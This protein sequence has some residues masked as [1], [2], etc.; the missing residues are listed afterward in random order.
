MADIMN[1]QQPQAATPRMQALRNLSNQ[2]PVANSQLAQ[3]QQAARNIQLQQ[4]VKAAPTTANTT[5][6]AQQTGAAV[7]ENAGKQLIQNAGQAIQQNGQVGSVINQEQAQQ[8][9][10]R[11]QGLQSS[12]REQAMDNVQRLA[13]V[14]EDAKKELYDK[15]MKF[16]KDEQGRTVLNER[17]LADYARVSAQNEQQYAQYAQSAQQ[18]NQRNLQAMENAYNLVKEDLVQKYA[19]AEQA[20]D[21]TTMREIA[22]MRID[23]D[24]RIQQER[25]RADNNSA[26]WGAGG[27]VLGTAAGAVATGGNPAGAKAGGALGGALGGIGS[28][29]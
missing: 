14:S 2:L 21:Q 8:A 1:A 20:K 9:Q 5:Q 28:S 11:T 18:I 4:A 7:A 27:S 24:A 23:A 10:A 16:Q 12:A 13:Q 3:G 6:T 29:L 26:A 22:Q 17:Q 19:Q 15:Q 25:N